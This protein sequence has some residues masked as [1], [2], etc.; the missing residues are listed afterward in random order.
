MKTVFAAFSALALCLNGSAQDKPETVRITG[1]FVL[2]L[3]EGEF[4]NT[5]IVVEGDRI[6]EI[7]PERRSDYDEVD[8][9]IYLDGAYILPGLSDSHVHL[10]GQTGIFGYAGLAESLPRA[11]VAGVANAKL[12]LESGFTT[13]RNLGA[14]GYAD[15]ALR[16]AIN[17]GEVPGPRMVVSGPPLGITGGHC[18][19]NLLPFEYKQKADGVADG[20][21]AVRQKV[22]QNVKYGADVIKFCG[23]G[24]VFSKGTKIGAQQF[25]AEEMQAIVDEAALLG[26]SVAVHAHG[27]D[28][29]KTA[30]KAG[31]DSVEHASL[32][33]D[34]GLRLAAER[35]TIL[36]MDI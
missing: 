21:W 28:G 25:S 14:P 3:K 30:I 4:V 22:R 10:I 27:T 1:A 15:V 26:V 34:E 11:T 9:T 17:D 36:S 16:D 32:I 12:M 18:D 7:G 23:T 35:G 29:I 8:R 6:A 20:P 19:N 33:D 2:D 31:V 13:V 5:D 24:G